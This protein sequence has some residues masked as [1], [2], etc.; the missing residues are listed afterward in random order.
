VPPLP[1]LTGAAASRTVPVSLDIPAIGVHTP[2]VRL[3]LD[4]A[5]ALV[6]PADFDLAGWYSGGPAPGQPGPAVLAGHVDSR[7]GPA[8][9]YRLGQ[10]APGEEVLVHRADGS[11]LRYLVA[12]TVR[13]PKARFPTGLVYAPVPDTELRLITCGGTF[14]RQRRSYRDDIV[15]SAVA[16]P[17]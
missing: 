13:Y 11:T 3:H 17:L 12:A 5:G 7:A 2:L 4:G 16:G 9:F 8:V 15:V 6:P 1:P 14:D 10:L